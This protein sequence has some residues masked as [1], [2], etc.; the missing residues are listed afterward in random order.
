MRAENPASGP[1]TAWP[2]RRGGTH[3]QA[4]KAPQD[5]SSSRRLPQGVPGPG[6]GA[7]RVQIGRLSRDARRSEGGR[8]GS[9]ARLRGRQHPGFNL[10]S[11]AGRE[12]A[13]QGPLGGTRRA[14][15]AEAPT[16]DPA[17]TR[18]R[19]SAWP[20]PRTARGP[21]AAERLRPRRRRDQ[22]REATPRPRPAPA[23]P[24]PAPPQSSPSR[25]DFA[26]ARQV[27]GS[28]AGLR[29]WGCGLRGRGAPG[30]GR[31]PRRTGAVV[32]GLGVLSGF[33]R[34]R[35]R[36]PAG[37]WASCA[38]PRRCRG[39]GPLGRSGPG[40][41]WGRL[42]RAPR[43]PSTACPSPQDPRRPRPPRRAPP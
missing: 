34:G 36:T 1:D 31:D 30:R 17:S 43:A 5:L 40:R 32:R 26:A 23:P 33:P 37:P 3:Q 7:C 35:W 11:G 21:I 14:R 2:A 4:E 20:R 15:D 24:G 18:P 39:P 12:G 41:C 28:P 13:T 9:R 42:D 22:S 27:S 16:R 25:G 10:R 19:P 38:A 6:V 8:A 29:V